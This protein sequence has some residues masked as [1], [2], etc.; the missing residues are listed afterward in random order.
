MKIVKPLAVSFGFRPFLVLQQQRLCV[1]SLVGFGLGDG[2]RRLVA[3]IHLWPAIGEVIAGAV[4]E[5][6]PKAHGEV[7]VYGSC[8]APGPFPVRS[9]TVRLQVTRGRDSSSSLVDK[10]LAVFGDRYWEGTAALESSKES[11]P[12]SLDPSEPIPFREM[13]LG[14]ERSFGG[15]DFPKN[16]L[17]K[18]T[19]R[20]AVEG[21]IARLP[22]PNV[23]LPLKLLK[24]SLDRPDP[25]SFGP[26]DVSWP[27][28]RARA[29]SYGGKWLEADFPG[30]ARDTDPAFFGTAPDDQRIEGFFRGDEA[31]LLEN[32]HPT[33]PVVRGRLP[34]VGAR[35]LVRRNGQDRA[36]EVSM[37]LDTV[38]F[39]PGKEIGILVFRGQTPV[40]EDDASDIAVACAACEDLEAPR[41]PEHYLA[42]LEKRLD[43]DRSPLAALN[44]SDLLPPFGA[45]CGIAELL[46]KLE[47]PNKAHRDRVHARALARVRD[48]LAKANVEDPDAVLAKATEKSPLVKRLEQLPDPNDPDDMAAFAKAMDELRVQGEQQ[49]EKAVQRAKDQLDKMERDIVEEKG[50]APTSPE[51]EQAR[52]EALGK[53]D[54]AR[55][56]FSGKPPAEDAP[57]TGEGPPKSRM[58]AMLAGFRD[59][60]VEPDP[61]LLEKIIQLDRRALDTYRSSA[62]HGPAARSLDR[63][64]RERAR[65]SVIDLRAAGKSFAERDWTRY[66]LSSLDLR[67]ADLQKTLLEGADLTQTNLAEANLAGGV[68]AHAILRQTCFDGA[69]L[70]GANLGA[71][72]IEGASFSGAKLRKAF[73]S[74]SKVISASFKGADLT[75]VQWLEAELGAVDFDGAVADGITFLP[76]AVPPDSGA[77]R[78]PPARVDLTKC[79]FARARLKRA[80][81]LNVNVGGTD[82]TEADLEQATFLSARGDTAN[83]CRA[84]LR[85]LQAVMECSFVGAS[86]DGADLSGA[87]LRGCNLRGASFEGARLDGADLSGCDLTGANLL[88]VRAKGVRLIGA[89][90]TQA[91]L[92]G[93]DL[94]EG[95]LQKSTLYGADLSGANLFSANLGLIRVDTETRVHGANLKRALL[96]PKAKTP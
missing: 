20:L 3:D 70:E 61:T 64:A 1:S 36:E 96:F 47:D 48:Q 51:A 28:R 13:P 56:A 38:V 93:A 90:L 8:H 6:L 68:L 40:L 65:R 71:A 78:E 11:V 42:A 73:L 66:D 33:L 30:F 10:Q 89:D 83:F 16:P 58:P 25:A 5:G 24:S 91:K 22:L 15:Q 19:A 35:V 17:G 44:E 67:A 14:W 4:D 26:I 74:K 53:I 80:K 95:M 43:K 72:T 7:L 46:G 41:P 63:E 45:S 85:K 87:F 49:R 77:P 52:R 50:G 27:Q 86:F 55:R 2:V 75:G 39:L 31:Y 32:M 81:F 34:G 23:E 60:G 82:F 69:T 79:R 54:A 94:M 84:S 12:M 9:T 29:G 57:S 59:A 18:G 88:R 21:G 37:V 62:H 92:A 76:K